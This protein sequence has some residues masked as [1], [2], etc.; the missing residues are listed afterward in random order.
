MDDI[1][2]DEGFFDSKRPQIGMIICGFNMHYPPY[3]KW[4]RDDTE[5]EDYALVIEHL[6]NKIDAQ[7]IL[8]SHSNSFNLQPLFSLGHGRDYPI[9][10]QLFEVVK[11][12]GIVDI[13]HV[14]CIKNAY[15][16]KVTKALIGKLDFFVTGR[17]H[18][19]VAA[20]SQYVPTVLIEYVQEMDSTKA[21]G[22]FS[23]L[24]LAECVAMPYSDDIISKIDNC[25]K[26][27]SKIIKKLKEKIPEIQND[28]RSQFDGMVDL[29]KSS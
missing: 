10:K 1:L 2:K 3:D 27:R 24:G 16:P 25:F 23:I 4:P 6:V 8:M 17:L 12:R 29:L 15:L 26:G 19:S 22:F 13:H 28:C 9:V 11:K 20:V 18:S 5:Y 7:V 21:I 14:R